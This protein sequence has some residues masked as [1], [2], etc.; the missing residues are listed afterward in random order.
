MNTLDSFPVDAWYPVD[1]SR[2]VSAGAV[3]LG[4]LFG[5]ELALWRTTAGQVQAWSNRC[6]HRSVRLTL[7]LIVDD[8]LVCRYH[9]W[10]YASNGQCVAI[11]AHPGLSPPKAACVRTYGVAEGSGLV[12]ASIG[13]PQGEA[14]RLTPQ[15][16]L[17]RHYVLPISPDAAAGHAAADGFERRDVQRFERAGF[18]GDTAASLLL[19]PIGSER[20]GAYLFIEQAPALAE[21]AAQRQQANLAFKAL[22]AR[23]TRAAQSVHE[24]VQHA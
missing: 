13:A 7:G 23:W 21:G 11:P 14:P 17:C 9:G 24:G 3:T 4:L 1:A 2:H 18:I 10:R 20:T 12:W 5:Q 15:A 19:Q 8:H 22:A 16:T 6:P